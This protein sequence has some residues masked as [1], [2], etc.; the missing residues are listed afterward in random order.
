MSKLCT[1][2]LCVAIHRRGVNPV[3]GEGTTYLRLAD[4]AAGPFLVL[5]QPCGHDHSEVARSVALDQ[6]ELAAL[7]DAAQKLLAGWPKDNIE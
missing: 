5:E 2:V 1:T 3:F 7:V 6:E 4:D